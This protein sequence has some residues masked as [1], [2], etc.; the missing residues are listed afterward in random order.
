MEILLSIK[1]KFW[2][3]ASQN[4]AGRESFGKIFPKTFCN[5]QILLTLDEDP[6]MLYDGIR[7]VNAL[8]WLLGKVQC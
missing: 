4:F 7:Q 8:D 6:E 5:L 1:I 3:E 2:E